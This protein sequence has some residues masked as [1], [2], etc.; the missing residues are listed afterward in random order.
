MDSPVSVTII[1]LSFCI[2]FHTFAIDSVVRYFDD[3]GQHSVLYMATVVWV[4]CL[5]GVSTL[6]MEANEVNQWHLYRKAM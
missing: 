2:G 3:K 1:Y 4:E 5:P 6:K